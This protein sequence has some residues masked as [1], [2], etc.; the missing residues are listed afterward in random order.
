MTQYGSGTGTVAVT[1]GSAEVMLLIPRLRRMIVE[2]T[3]TTYSDATLAEI[4]GLYP[5]E[6]LRGETPSVESTATPGTLEANPDWTPTYDLNAAAGEIWAEKAGQ[7]VADFDFSA[8]G[9]SFNRSTK[10]QFCM[11]QSRFYRARRN[12]STITLRPEPLSQGTE[13]SDV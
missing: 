7:F 11:Q 1:G 6:D 12:P 3:T 8:D 10:Y 4:I 9:G 5:C 13:A 2:P